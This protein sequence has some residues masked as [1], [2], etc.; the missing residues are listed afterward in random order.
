[1]NRQIRADEVRV[2]DDSGSMLGVMSVDEGVAK[3]KERG[4][5]LIL[6]SPNANPP[7]CK[8]I[9]YGQYKYEANRKE[10]S[11][12]KSQKSGVVKELKMSPIIGEH[13]LQVR[14]RQAETF[15][16]KGHKVKV[17]VVFRGRAN[18]HPEVGFALIDRY[19]EGVAEWGLPEEEPRKIGRN[20]IVM[21]SPLK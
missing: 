5:D 9:E 16:K 4:L 3:A 21:L 18:T 12:R 14:L 17:C 11:A 1:M 2:I 20:I 7:V 19:L 6:V 8:I 10:K 15:L 13:D